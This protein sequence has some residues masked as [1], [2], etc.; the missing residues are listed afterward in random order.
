MPRARTKPAASPAAARQDDWTSS[1]S[2]LGGVRDKHRG[3]AFGR[4]PRLTRQALD[5]LYEQHALAARIVDLVVDDA[6][7]EGWSLQSVTTADGSVIDVAEVRSALDDIGIDAALSQAA[8]WSRLHGGAL[9]VIPAIG[10]GVASEVMQIVPGQTHLMRLVVVPAERAQPQ[11]QD[12]GLFSPTYGR[13]LEWQITGLASASTLVH[14][15]RVI[16][17]EAIQLPIDSL[18]LYNRGGWGPSI[19]ERVWDELGRDGAAASHAVSM[20]YIAS[21]TYLKLAN[22]KEDHQTR[23]GAAKIREV[24]GRVRENLDS[25]G[26]LGMDTED[27]IGNLSITLAGATDIMDRTRDRVTAAAGR[28]PREILFNESPAGLGAGVL[29][30]PQEIYFAGVRAWQHEVLEPA[31]DRI[32]EVYFAARGIDATAW[33]IDFAPLWTKSDT[34]ESEAHARNAAAD[35]AYVAMGAITAD[36]VREQRFSQGVSGAL[37][38]QADDDAEPLDLEAGMV[39]ANIEP[40]AV[41][42]SSPEDTAMNGAQISSMLEIIVKVNTGEL[43]YDQGLGALGVA[44]ATLRGRE[45]SVLGPRPAVAPVNPNMPPPVAAVGDE[46]GAELEPPPSTGPMP[47]DLV[48]VRE[49]AEKFRVPTRTITLAIQREQLG[50]WGLGAHKMVSLAEVA[51]LATAHRATE[52]EAPEET[53]P[54]ETAPDA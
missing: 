35:T 49:A 40:V 42:V 10:S 16:P 53:A 41:A 5:V 18:Q 11:Q 33:E 4:R 36:E 48:P 26:L 43:S 44:F 24:L 28:Y 13:T 54:E 45:S 22:Y 30:G 38:I 32:L 25:L 19:L 51:E 2:S 27:E 52:P 15:S 21:I 20:L 9:L 12:V 6:L 8:K 7:R 3:I 37:S 29:S 31:I 50:Y 17:F 14:H 1:T 39:E 34:H 23:E 46:P 47:D